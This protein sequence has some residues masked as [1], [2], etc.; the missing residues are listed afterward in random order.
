VRAVVRNRAVYQALYGTLNALPY[1]V[2]RTT[3]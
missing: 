2:L 1:S 3:T